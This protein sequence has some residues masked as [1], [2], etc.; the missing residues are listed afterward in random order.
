[1]VQGSQLITQGAALVL[2]EGTLAQGMMPPAPWGPWDWVWTVQL[3]LL[4]VMLLAFIFRI[5]QDITVSA[6]SR[7]SSRGE[8]ALERALPQ[9][10]R[11]LVR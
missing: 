9:P 10:V 8:E 5:V 11:Q 3:A 4:A 6:W 1:M 7:G 2:E